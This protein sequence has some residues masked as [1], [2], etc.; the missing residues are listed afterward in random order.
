MRQLKKWL[1][2]EVERI[3]KLEK[4]GKISP[5]TAREKRRK[6]GVRG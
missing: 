2:D 1:A 5:R 6:L 4:A 3:G